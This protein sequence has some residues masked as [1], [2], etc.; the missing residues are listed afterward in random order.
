MQLKRLYLL[1]APVGA[2]LLTGSACQSAHKQAALAP[3]PRPAPPAISA[4]AATRPLA[5]PSAPLE[6]KPQPQ[7]GDSSQSPDPVNDLIQ[8]VEAE[9]QAGQDNYKAGQ[10][11][12]AKQ[13]FDNAFNSLLSGPLEVH[14]DARLESEFEKLLDGINSLELAALQQGD[15][16][17]EQKSEP[18]PI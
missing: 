15:G 14:S 9:Y 13:N 4:S 12:A 5:P 6:I 11:D 17:A 7:R 10:L 2:V 3:P 16:F 1:I 8:K 18:A